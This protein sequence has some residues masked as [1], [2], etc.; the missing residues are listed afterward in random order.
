MGCC[1]EVRFFPSFLTLTPPLSHIRSFA[2]KTLVI[3]AFLSFAHIASAAL[4]ARSEL[5]LAETLLRKGADQVGAV[6]CF[7]AD[8]CVAITSPHLPKLKPL[9]YYRL[10]SDLA[11]LLWEG[12]G[13]EEE[14]KV[15]ENEIASTLTGYTFALRLDALQPVPP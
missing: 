12:E 1:R 3:I 4:I 13:R 9:Q 15:F 14:A 11:S 6:F 8:D 10:L 7:F 2:A 5:T